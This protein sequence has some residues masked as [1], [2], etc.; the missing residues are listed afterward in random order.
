MNERSKRKIKRTRER[1]KVR[2]REK[3]KEV[4]SKL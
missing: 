3:R 4:F 1:G 2:K